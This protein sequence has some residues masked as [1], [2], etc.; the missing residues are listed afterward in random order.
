MKNK[1]DIFSKVE[2]GI[3]FVV[4]IDK[5]GNEVFRREKNKQTI[6]IANNIYMYHKYEK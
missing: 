1:S 4:V 3:T 2:N 5:N 6:S